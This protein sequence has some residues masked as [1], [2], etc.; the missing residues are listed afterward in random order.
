MAAHKVVVATWE[1]LDGEGLRRRRFFGDVVDVDEAE[2]ARGIAAGALAEV[3][4]APAD[5]QD[6]QDQSGGTDPWTVVDVQGQAVG[7]LPGGDDQGDESQ[8]DGADATEDAPAD[9]V[10]KPKKTAKLEAWRDYAVAKGLDADEIKQLT[11]EQL[12]ELVSD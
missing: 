10:E 7:E 11:K 4:E 1:I 9:E 6:D 2:A 3:D 12:I 5:D 8:P